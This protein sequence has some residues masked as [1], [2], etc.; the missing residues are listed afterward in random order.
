VAD[1][2]YLQ[3]PSR[4][5]IWD[6]FSSAP[7]KDCDPLT[8]SRWGSRWPATAR[9]PGFVPDVTATEDRKEHK[10]TLPKPA[11]QI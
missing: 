1:S 7:N 10:E 11:G 4:G 8:S 2:D 5:S 6:L 9:N 3:T